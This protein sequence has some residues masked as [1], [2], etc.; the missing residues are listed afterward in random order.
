MGV[1]GAICISI[2]PANG[3]QSFI[4]WP[5]DYRDRPGRANTN[6]SPHYHLFRIPC[7][8]MKISLALLAQFVAVAEE[9]A[10]SRAAVRLRVAQPWLSTRLRELEEE[11]GFRLLDRT[12]RGTTLTVAGTRYHKAA[13]GLLRQAE[14]LERLAR[15]IAEE[16][17][18]IRVGAIP[19]S[20][21][22]PERN[23]L[24][25]VIRAGC[26]ESMLR[27]ENHFDPELRRRVMSGELDAAFVIGSPELLVPQQ[28]PLAA[29][30][31][32]TLAA[33]RGVRI[34]T[35]LRERNPVAWDETAGPLA[36]AGVELVELPE[37]LRDAL[38]GQ[39]ARE[40]LPVLVLDSF[41]AAAPDVHG[42]SR[43]R[44]SDAELRA[45]FFLIR[46]RRKRHGRIFER[47]W[48]IAAE[49]C[50]RQREHTQI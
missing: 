29:I 38:I 36:R 26:G 19:D 50:N 3:F 1:V 13:K 46:R 47:F 42:M 23:R 34:A 35:F 43:H 49:C 41:D 16:S 15:Q 21:Y 10:F 4:N 12:P 7:C 40:G 9:G 39:A 24:I 25:D 28:H 6:R 48:S 2:L 18:G 30:G 31:E 17:A 11:L 27:L 44:L 14:G 22:I 32:L 45:D 8:G 20:F 37:S 33:L 5:G